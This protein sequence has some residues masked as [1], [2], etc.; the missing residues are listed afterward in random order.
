MQQLTVLCGRGRLGTLLAQ[1]L[2]AQGPLIAGRIDRERGLVAPDLFAD[3]AQLVL[4]FV[5]RDTTPERSGWLG[6]LAGL[7][8]QVQRGELRIGRV[9]LVSSTGVYEGI[10]QGWVTAETSPV[11]SSPRS[12]G[13]IDAEQSIAHLAEHSHIFRLSGLT[14]PGYERY[15][16]R[17]SS[18]HQ[19]RSAVEVRAA[20]A[21]IIQTLR[22]APNGHQRHIVTDGMIYVGTEPRPA[23]RSDPMLNALAAEHRLLL[24]DLIAR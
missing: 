15:D 4:C 12:A 7:K 16:P 17:A 2:S 21:T 3:I 8:A 22:A 19:P 20:A 23:D 11:A 1:A 9:A 10:R 24:A 14:G 13:L 6:L 5:P 18:A